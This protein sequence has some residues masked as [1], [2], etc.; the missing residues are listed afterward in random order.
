[1][2]LSHKRITAT[3]CVECPVT[4]FILKPG[5]ALPSPRIG[6][7]VIVPL[8][9]RLSFGATA[10]KQKVHVLPHKRKAFPCCVWL[11]PYDY[12]LARNDFHNGG[13]A[14]SAKM[15]K[16]CRTLCK[17][18]IRTALDGEILDIGLCEGSAT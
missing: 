3:F 10:K 13:F 15:F 18:T 12:R 14:E 2:C 4:T 5:S 7:L 1:M 8:A 11:A 16:P 6:F 9:F 17:M